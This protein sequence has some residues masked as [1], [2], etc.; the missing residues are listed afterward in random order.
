MHLKIAI[1][2]VLSFL[3]GPQLA[4]AL[5][6]PPPILPGSLAAL[7]ICGLGGSNQSLGNHSDGEFFTTKSPNLPSELAVFAGKG[8]NFA[9][10]V[11]RDGD[12]NVHYF[13]RF[14]ASKDLPVCEVIEQEM[15]RD[16]TGEGKDAMPIVYGST[17]Y[18]RDYVRVSGWTPEPPEEWLRRGYP[19]DAGAPTVTFAQ[20]AD[21]PCPL[22]DDPYY[23]RV[24][25]V[26]P[27]IFKGMAT[28]LQQASGS[29]K[30]FE[31]SFVGSAPY[32]KRGLLGRGFIR[33][34]E[35]EDTGCWAYLDNGSSVEFDLRAKGLAITKVLPH[36][37]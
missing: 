10:R 3:I 13:G 19:R 27:G 2:V 6:P 15:F 26:P 18:N 17:D 8:G 30:G 23:A 14:A 7:E 1:S 20:M 37:M 32:N 36:A 21:G 31:N 12:R 22:G 29:E 35:C 28:T 33:W 5:P 4:H 25:N 9:F 11:C 16:T 34:A 24:I